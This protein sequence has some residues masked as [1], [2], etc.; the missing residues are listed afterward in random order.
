[1][2]RTRRR[3]RPALLAALAL[4]APVT[5]AAPPATAAP[6][7]YV[8]DALGDSYAAGFGAGPALDACARTEAAHP[9]VLDGRMRIELDDLAA[10]SGA[11][12]RP[13]V[14]NNLVAQLGALDRDT[15]L[16]SVSIGGN[17]IGWG[18]TVAACVIG[19][20]AQCAQALGL[21]S[22]AI[23]TALPPLLDAA[24]AQVAAAAPNAHV[25][26]TGYP[27]LFSPEH[28]AYHNASPAEQQSLNAAADQLNAVISAAADRHGFQ[29]VDVTARFVDHGV[30]APEAWIGGIEDPELF[31]PTAQGQ[32]AYGVALRAAVRPSD[33]R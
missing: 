26:V 17:D 30:N 11:A 23:S 18:T 29:F 10:C 12:A 15:D 13:T 19:Q 27:R 3:A 9:F 28:G 1:M 2:E 22:F 6:S 31:H 8:Y 14:P 24:Y 21:T 25:V 5:V 7:T 32:H 16:V 33:L 20:D 4:A